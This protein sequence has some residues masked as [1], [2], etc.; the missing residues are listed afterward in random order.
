MKHE[1]SQGKYFTGK[2]FMGLITIQEKIFSKIL[3]YK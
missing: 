1:I 2:S 3:P